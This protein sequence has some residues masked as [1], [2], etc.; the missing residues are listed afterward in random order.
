MG[1]GL[2]YSINISR[3]LSGEIHLMVIASCQYIMRIK[4]LA[5]ELFF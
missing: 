5:P 4:L 1:W 2:S 3:R